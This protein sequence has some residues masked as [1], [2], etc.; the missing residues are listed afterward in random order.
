MAATHNFY[1]H[2]PALIHL[3]CKF[4]DKFPRK[5]ILCWRDNPD[6][7]HIILMMNM[8]PYFNSFWFQKFGSNQSKPEFTV[9]LRG[10][11]VEWASKDKSSKKHVIEVQNTLNL[12]KWL[13]DMLGSITLTFD[14]FLFQLK[15]RQGT[16]LLIQSEIDSVINDWYRALTETINTHVSGQWAVLFLSCRGVLGSI[17]RQGRTPVHHRQGRVSKS[18]NLHVIWSGMKPTQTLGEH[19]NS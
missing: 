15:T 5:K 18:P 10:G 1:T 3:Y 6:M 7:T 13:F 9:D 19:L 2:I 8:L 11:S 4:S 14:L 17:E 16:E 12:H